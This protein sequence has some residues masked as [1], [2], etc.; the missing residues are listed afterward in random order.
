LASA[1]AGNATGQAP[2][3]GL[4]FF[5]PRR[6]PRDRAAKLRGVLK[7]RIA[8]TPHH[9]DG[10]PKRQRGERRFALWNVARAPARRRC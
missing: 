2:V 3:A 9:R 7:L 8:V 10:K 5:K 1:S 6:R 4:L